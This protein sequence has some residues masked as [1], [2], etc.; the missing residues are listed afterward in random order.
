MEPARHVG[1]FALRK[2]GG[3]VLATN[4]GLELFDFDSGQLTPIAYPEGKLAHTRFNDG[5]VDSRGRFVV[6]EINLDSKRSDAFSALTR[7]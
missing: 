4:H 5:K 7:T 6:G 2:G 1:S 3:A